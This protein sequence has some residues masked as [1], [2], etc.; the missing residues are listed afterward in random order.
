MGGTLWVFCGL[1]PGP[2]GRALPGES[3]GQ[4]GARYPIGKL[5]PP[6]PSPRGGCALV[7]TLG[8]MRGRFGTKPFLVEKRC[9]PG[10]RLNEVFLLP[11]WATRSPPHPSPSVT[12]S[13]QGEASGSCGPTR[14]KRPKS[15]HVPGPR[16]SLTTAP[17]RPTTPK[18]ASGNER[19]IKNRGSRG[20]APGPLSPH[21]S[22]ANYNRKCNSGRKRPTGRQQSGRIRESIKTYH[23]RRPSCELPPS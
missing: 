19:V 14:K 23:Q 9:S 6:K 11:R 1:P 12:A 20:L 5:P 18:P 13:P 16:N 21:F 2:A 10:C 17:L 3:I 4:K 7:H 8:R 22:G 15:G